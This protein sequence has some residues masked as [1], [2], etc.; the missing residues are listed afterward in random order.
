M[1]RLG[2]IVAI[3]LAIETI[4]IWWIWTSKALPRLFL[5]WGR[6][7]PERTAGL[8]ILVNAGWVALAALIAVAYRDIGPTGSTRTTVGLA[9]TPLLAV[10]GPI[11]LVW[12]PGYYGLG[13]MFDRKRLEQDGASPETAKAFYWT[14]V[15]FGYLAIAIGILGLIT[16]F[17]A[18]HLKPKPTQQPGFAS[19]GQVQVTGTTLPCSEVEKIVAVVTRHGS[20]GRYAW[21]KVDG[22]QCSADQGVGVCYDPQTQIA[23]NLP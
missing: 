14:G 18:Q 4:V 16:W 6:N 22:L 8:V 9:L 1:S 13:F 10:L 20:H 12:L 17:P 19:C 21:L 15:P 23:F 11:A 5:R 7:E 2:F 3:V